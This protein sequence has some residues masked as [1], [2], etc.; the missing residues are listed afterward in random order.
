L[1]DFLRESRLAAERAAE[2]TRQM[3][4]FSRKQMLQP[5]VIR[6]GEVLQ[7]MQPMVRRLVG[8]DIAFNISIRDG[9][10]CIRADKSQLEQVVMNLVVNARDAMPEGGVL[11]IDVQAVHFGDEY[12]S[13]QHGVAP[14]RYIMMAVSDNGV[15]MD[16]ATTAQ[17]FEPFFSTKGPG[18]GTGLGLATVFGIVKQNGGNIWVYSEPGQGTTF[19]LYLP[20]SEEGPSVPLPVPAEPAPVSREVTILVVEDEAQLRSMVSLVLRAEGYLV[21]EAEDPLRAIE[22]SR[23]QAGP[24]DLLLT[25]VVMPHLNGRKLAERLEP[26][27][28][29]MRVVYMSGYTEHTIVHQGVLDPSIHFLPKPIVPSTLRNIV[30]QVL[31]DPS[32]DGAMQ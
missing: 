4:A 23:A 9:E 29:E 13:A 18:H 30:R 7:S 32:R 3:L 2:L 27:R 21:L 20:E 28:P 19:K 25:D 22:L 24:I 5:R 26:S 15:G 12:L 6:V 10:R 17:I 31:R 11:T 16:T 8:E 14:G 1:T